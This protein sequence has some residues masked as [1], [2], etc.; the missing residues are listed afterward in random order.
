MTKKSK[1][2]RLALAQINP[3]V[4][5]LNGNAQKVIEFIKKAQISK[6]DLIAFPELVVTGYPPEDLLF[7]PKF[8]SDNLKEIKKIA[9][10][11]ESIVVVAGFVDKVAGH[12]YNAAAVISNKKIRGVYHKALLPNYG[13]FDE[14]RYFSPGEKESV[15]ALGEIIF[16]V[17][18]CEDIWHQAGPLGLTAKKGASLII[19]INASPYHAGKRF[20]REKILTRQAKNHSVAIAYANLVGGQDELVFDGQSMV[21]DSRGK[22][23]AMAKAFEEELLV[24]DIDLKSADKKSFKKAMYLEDFHDDKPVLKNKNP[25]AGTLSEEEEIYGALV[26]GLKDYIKKNGFGKCIL[27]LS[28]GIDSSLVASIAVDAAG[29]ENVVGVCMPSVFTSSESVE[30]A[31]RLAENLGIKFITVPI[32]DIFQRYIDTL[33][34]SFEGKGPDVTEENLQARVRGNILMALSNKFG[35]LALNTGNKSEVSCGY[36]TLYGDMIGGFGVIKDVPKTLV[37]R[38]SIYKNKRSGFDLIPQR[39][40]KKAPTAEL[41]LNQKDSDVLPEYDVLD[42]ILKLY[43]EQNKSVE[44]IIKKGSDRGTVSRVIKMV[45]FNEYKRRQ[46]PPGIKITPRAFGR[47]RRMP[48][49]NRY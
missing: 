43:V 27:G 25:I 23:I 32:N 16:G 35:Y 22:I 6:V 21:I 41:K 26:L 36:C 24:V 48:I 8:V 49:T 11:A 10:I 2:I 4:G 44:E 18:I 38:L 34:D 7:K 28:G 29:K 31:A 30:D 40:I 17:N 14:K 46:A 42:K 37:Y 15:F 13:V 3:V 9:S 19:N 1:K 33:R 45:D 47:D 39:V 20:D 12:L 5:D